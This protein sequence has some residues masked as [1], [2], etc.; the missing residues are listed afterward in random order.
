MEYQITVNPIFD[1]N[2]LCRWKIEKINSFNDAIEKIAYG[3]INLGTTAN[4]ISFFADEIVKL[5]EI[6][7]RKKRNL[8]SLKFDL[9]AGS[10]KEKTIGVLDLFQLYGL[11]SVKLNPLKI[12]I[13]A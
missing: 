13:S 1:T 4:P 8:T 11:L 6:E 12:Q 5:Y 2:R 10:K 9:H 7:T 3:E